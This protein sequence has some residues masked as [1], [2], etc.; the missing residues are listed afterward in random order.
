MIGPSE[1]REIIA[2]YRKHGWSLSRV[3]LSDE[4]KRRL[5]GD[6]ADLFG[7]AEIIDSNI[8][9]AWFTRRSRPGSVTWE[10]RR[11]TALPFAL[12]EVLD[13]SASG[14]ERENALAGAED[15]LRQSLENFGR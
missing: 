7:D 9:A 12:V 11:F 13:D 14:E 10:L 1:I 2:T 3:L 15:R 6:L 4:S 8:D 5:A